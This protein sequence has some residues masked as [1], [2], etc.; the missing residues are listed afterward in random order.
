[1]KRIIIFIIATIAFLACVFG[2][3]VYRIDPFARPSVEVSWVDEYD[4]YT[5]PTK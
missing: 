2:L 1:M 4:I 3:G 5:L